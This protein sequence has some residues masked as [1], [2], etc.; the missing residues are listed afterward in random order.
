MFL[1][2][3]VAFIF[4]LFLASVHNFTV[5]F[6]FL[7][8]PPHLPYQQIPATNGE[9]SSLQVYFC[10]T[11]KKAK[12]NERS[13]H[14]TGTP[15]RRSVPV[16]GARRTQKRRNAL[17][18]PNEPPSL[19]LLTEGRFG[20]IWKNR[21]PRAGWRCVCVFV[22]FKNTVCISSVTWHTSFS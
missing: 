4:F 2:F 8:P 7:P 15:G 19:D 18:Q 3:L 22:F 12:Q 13:S 5:F 14:N 1:A 20:Y 16:C 10:V 17:N 6:Y 11:A 9:C 21:L